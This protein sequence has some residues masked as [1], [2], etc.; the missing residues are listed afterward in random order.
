MATNMPR[1][2]EPRG[3]MTEAWEITNRA[4][5][6]AWRRADV[7]ASAIGALFDAHP[8]LTRQQLAARMR[9]TSDSGTTLPAGNA[10]MRRG[11]IM[12]PGVAVA[13]AEERPHWTLEK[14]TTYHR[15]P[16]HRLGATPDYFI[17]STDPA[18]PGRGILELK[19]TNPE[20]WDKWQAKPPLGYVLQCVVQMMCTGCEWGWIAT[21]V[22]SHSLPIHYTPVP[23]H[24]AAEARILSAVAAWW[25]D[26]DSGR[27][28]PAAEAEGLAEAL[29]DGSSIDLS[30]DN[31]LPGLLD[32]REH[33]RHVL[34]GEEA[35]LKEIDY[36]IKNR[37]GRARTAWL[38]GWAISFQTQH[39]RET[40]I[41][42]KDIRVLRIRRIAEHDTEETPNG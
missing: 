36:Q 3:M 21:M 20:Q 27:L 39:R 1:L 16:A 32:E 33:I 13:V 9:S 2:V 30:R 14:A 26:F 24:P 11:R 37:V 4:E 29:D 22:T 38:P 31:A 41:P 25:A 7:T 5:W 10:A 6:L 19:T 17:T 28:A 42:A 23:R 8:Y 35:R 12:E 40:V 34:T 15:L 18:E